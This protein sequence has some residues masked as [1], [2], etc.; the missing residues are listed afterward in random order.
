MSVHIVDAMLQDD[1]GKIK[2]FALV[3]AMIVMQLGICV[4]T[5]NVGD[6]FFVHLLRK[7]NARDIICGD[8]KARQTRHFIGA[9]IGSQQVHFLYHANVAYFQLFTIFCVFCIFNNSIN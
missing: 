2:A 3:K 7:K 6:I 9:K 4:F 5:M 1:Q 8:G